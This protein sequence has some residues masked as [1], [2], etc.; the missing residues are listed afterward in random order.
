M[1]TGLHV[2]FFFQFTLVLEMAPASRTSRSCIALIGLLN[3]LAV[4]LV[5]RSS[6]SLLFR[7]ITAQPLS[8][9]VLALAF[10]SFD[11]LLLFTKSLLRILCGDVENLSSFRILITKAAQ[12]RVYK[13]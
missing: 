4:I 10:H 8:V 12:S 3:K 7:M 6:F 11:E 2:L 1:T 5:L 13:F 9:L